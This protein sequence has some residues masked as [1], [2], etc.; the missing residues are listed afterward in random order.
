MPAESKMRALIVTLYAPENVRNLGNT[1]QHY[2]LQEA[3]KSLGY[4]AGSLICPL[5]EPDFTLAAKN[6]INAVI[7]FPAKLAKHAAKIALSLIA[8]EKYREYMRRKSAF[9]LNTKR[10]GDIFAEFYDKFIGGKIY[11]AYREVLSAGEKYTAG[12]DIIIAGSDQVWAKRI[13]LTDEA[14][15]Y[16]YLFWAEKEKRACYAPSYGDTLPDSREYPIHKEGLEGFQLLS[17][18]EKSGCGFIRELT[19]RVAELVLDPVLLLTAEQWRKISRRPDFDVPEHY[20]LRYCWKPESWRGEQDRIAGGMK[21]I[22]VYDPFNEYCG[23]TGPREFIWLV[24]HADVVFSE[25]FHGTAFSLN[26]GKNFLSF[27][28]TRKDKGRIGSLLSETGL[29]GH[30]Y[31][32]EMCEIPDDIDYSA[33]REKLGTMREKSLK[34]LRECLKV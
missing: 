26:M 18:R 31:E 20:A 12:R 8:P 11:S 33:V 4:E 27:M 29:S 34:Y 19:G 25:S 23:R 2:A 22:D 30:I 16:Y 28:K 15:R 1:L 7:K 21:I 17:C 3:V 5:I 32:P 24:E 6:R 9:T 13:V 14:L 10:R